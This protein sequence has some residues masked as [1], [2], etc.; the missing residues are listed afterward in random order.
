MINPLFS[1]W[2]KGE[3]RKKKKTEENK[4]ITKIKIKLTFKKYI[5]NVNTDQFFETLNFTFMKLRI[6]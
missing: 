5:F 1:P 6:E 3:N 4:R 2:G